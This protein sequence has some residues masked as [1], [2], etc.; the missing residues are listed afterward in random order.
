MSFWDS[1]PVLPSTTQKFVNFTVSFLLKKN[2][3]DFRLVS[4]LTLCNSSHSKTTGHHIITFL[5]GILHTH[6]TTTTVN[7]TS[8][9]TIEPI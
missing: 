5:A 7:S 2:D 3:E 6:K 8:T 9:L 1:L 4:T